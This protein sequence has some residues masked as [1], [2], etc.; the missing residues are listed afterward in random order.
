MR[1]ASTRGSPARNRSRIRLRTPSRTSS[2]ARAAA[3]RLVPR[4][5]SRSP[6][7]WGPRQQAEPA[8]GR[9]APSRAPR[10]FGAAFGAPRRSP[11]RTHRSP[12]PSA[13][14]A[15]SS[16]G[17]SR[18]P[19]A[20]RPAPSRV[21]RQGRDP[22]F[23]AHG[24]RPPRRSLEVSPRPSPGGP[25]SPCRGRPEDLRLLY[26]TGPLSPAPYAVAANRAGQGA[27]RDRSRRAGRSTARPDGT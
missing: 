1:S 14:P 17:T 22:R 11:A 9:Q 23:R 24:P 27:I 26:R 19:S 12:R 15:R 8:S 10:P 4:P 3:S 13:R 2:R 6:R 21:P 18:E 16:S 5:R 25:A 20:R 7:R